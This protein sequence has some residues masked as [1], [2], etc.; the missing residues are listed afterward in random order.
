MGGL[1]A[2][3]LQRQIN[4]SAL[5]RRLDR[6]SRNG[7]QGGIEAKRLEQPQDLG[8][9]SLVHAQAAEGDTAI[10]PMVHESALTMIAACFTG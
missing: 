1:V 5:V 8:A 2:R 10:T 6:S 7:V 4:L 9:D 3:L